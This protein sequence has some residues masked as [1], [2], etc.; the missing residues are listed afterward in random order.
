MLAARLPG[1][2]A[3][4]PAAVLAVVFAMITAA[5]APRQQATAPSQGQQ[6][7]VQPS[8][9]TAPAV[10]EPPADV[11]LE[12]DIDYS[13]IG[14]RMQMDVVR[15]RQGAAPLP[16]VVCIHGG[17]FRGGTRQRYL[18]IAY[19]LA[20]HG[21]VA[22]AVSYRL[23]PMNQFP[24]P[25]EDVKAAVRFLR[26]NAARFGI[27]AERIGAVGGSAG[28][29]LALMLGLTGGVAEFEGPGPNQD[30][31]SRVQAVVNFYGP[32]DLTKSYE[33]GKSVDAAEVLPMFL[34]GD[35]EHNR[36]AHVRASP[37]QWVSP[38]DAATLTIH[39]TKDT[40]V[41]YEHAQ[42]LAERLEAAGVPTKLETIEGAGHGFKDA[43]LDR[44]NAAMVAWFDRWLA[45]RGKQRLLLVAD[46][47]PRG[48][49]VA[50]DWPSGRERWTLPN[51]RGHD[52]Q[53]L[54]NGH[55]LYTTGEWRRVVEVDSGGREVWS[56]GLAEGLRHPIA[57]ERLSN[58]NTVIG[59]MELGMVIEIN[60]AG[61]KVWEYKNPEMAERRMR[62]V[63][64]TFEGTTLISVERLNKVIEVDRGGNIIWTFHAIG[65]DERFPYQA[66][67][68]ANGNTLIGMAAPGE[69]VEVAP[70]GKI[71]RSAGG[72]NNAVRM[73]WCSGLE[74]LPGGGFLVSDYTGR[75]ILEFDS[76]WK[77]VHELR[78]ASRTVASV[79]M[80]P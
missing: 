15:P 41:A 12:A 30:R 68:L 1:N 14:G 19:H 51:N 28:G 29:H 61:E 25:V 79:S 70:D 35:L 53:M 5:Q 22:A 67:R 45:P 31:S 20:Q 46:H 60:P 10:P 7:R 49:I 71:V 64:R 39:G 18:P 16:A 59:D 13:N 74:P 27:D 72:L 42:W 65:G 50:L 11:I 63:R 48:E 69:I 37:L 21:Y 54:P 6:A 55:V 76:G 9:T 3:A 77:V 26:A 2:P 40:Y 44:A 52:V 36:P 38:N 24:A 62:S 33:P 57:A 34:G 73:G 17:G 75:R 47:G 23:S 43:D 58:G 8:A 66:H 80:I 78:M 4:I 32:T 56:Y